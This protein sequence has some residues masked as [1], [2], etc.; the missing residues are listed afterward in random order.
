[1]TRQHD[2]VPCSVEVGF[3]TASSFLVAYSV[4][5]SKGGIFL[6]CADPPPIGTSLTLKI[7][8][9]GADVHDVP[10][11]VTWIREQP[12][13]GRP[14]GMGVEFC[15]IDD[16]LG[17]VIDRLVAAFRGLS[18]LVFLPDDKDRAT[19]ARMVRSLMRSAEVMEAGDLRATET[20]LDDDDDVDL[21]IIDADACDGSG[22]LALRAAKRR[23][24]EIPVIALCGGDATRARALDLGAD[25]VALN[26]P[27]FADFQD[28]VLRALG[29]PSTVR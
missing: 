25:E 3:R 21:V 24:A 28:I 20:R 12:E 6:E 1:V 11:Q 19:V 26:L 29:R 22:W 5:L 7:S 15:G 10:G 9:A 23:D 4:N 16:T 8:V 17:A 2:R 18:V 14:A 27:T 13:A